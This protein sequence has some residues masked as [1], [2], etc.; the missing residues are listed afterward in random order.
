MDPDKQSASIDVL[1]KPQWNVSWHKLASCWCI[2]DQ[3]NRRHDGCRDNVPF[4]AFPA[5]RR[6]SSSSFSYRAG[7]ENVSFR[8]VEMK[9]TL[10]VDPQFME[11]TDLF[12]T[13]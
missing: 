11:L 5:I 8:Q 4:P 13:S 7:L 12:V 3:S 9:W 6:N 1:E 2:R 10:S